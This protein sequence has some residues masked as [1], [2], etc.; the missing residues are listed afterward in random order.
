LDD[1][2]LHT[3]SVD[4]LVQKLGSRQGGRDLPARSMTTQDSWGLQSYPTKVSLDTTIGH[5]AVS[6]YNFEYYGSEATDEESVWIHVSRYGR[7]MVRIFLGREAGKVEHHLLPDPNELI[8]LG[9]LELIDHEGRP[10]YP[11]SP[12]VPFTSR[13][14]AAFPAY[15]YSV[16]G[17]SN[18]RLLVHLEVRLDRFDRSLS[19]QTLT[20]DCAD[21]QIN[22]VR[23]MADYANDWWELNRGSPS[24]RASMTGA[25]RISDMVP[26][27]FAP[28]GFSKIQGDRVLSPGT[29]WFEEEHNDPIDF[30]SIIIISQLS[31]NRTVGFIPQVPQELAPQVPSPSEE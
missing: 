29:L 13:V 8:H 10:Y 28:D 14:P 2:I 30:Y 11:S 6:S 24:L 17:V 22:A 18:G 12:L 31:D 19:Y 4:D 16:S 23:Q 3:I 15:R 25:R 7:E 20:L 1:H 9:T 27:H 21:E 5:N 26:I